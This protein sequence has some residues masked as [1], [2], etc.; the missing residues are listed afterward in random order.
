[1]NIF[2]RCP[3]TVKQFKED[4]CSFSKGTYVAGRATCK[5]YKEGR[6]KAEKEYELKKPPHR[7]GTVQGQ[8]K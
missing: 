1:M 4:Q 6:G 2:T 7:K 3:G 5:V 8:K